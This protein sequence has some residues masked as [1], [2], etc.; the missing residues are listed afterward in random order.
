MAPFHLQYLGLHLRNLAERAGKLRS[1]DVVLQGLS[2]MGCL[3]D[4]ENAYG[5]AL[6]VDCGIIFIMEILLIYGVTVSLLDE[7][8]TVTTAYQ[9]SVLALF[10]LKKWNYYHG[11]QALADEMSRCR[12]CLQGWW[13]ERVGDVAN[14]RLGYQF[15]VLED[16][17]LR[18]EPVR[19]LSAF[20]L[21]YGTANAGAG[22]LVT[23][24]IVLIQFNM[25][26]VTTG[27]APEAAGHFDSHGNL[28]SILK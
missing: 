15:G 9:G 25:G 26:E 21:T 28:T 23:Y 8:V 11:G 27:C 10:Q 13:A 12:S 5:L 16:R 20:S 14:A 24:I 3:D 4:F 19:P 2:V 17:L 6:L 7:A 18:A 22:L 1:N